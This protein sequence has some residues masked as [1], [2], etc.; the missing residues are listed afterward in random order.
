MKSFIKLFTLGDKV[1]IVS[2]L[3]VALLFYGI[4]A[5][6]AFSEFAEVVEVR[7]DGELYAT[8]SLSEIRTSKKVKIQTDF[9]TN[10]LE[11]TPDGVRITD[12]SCPDKNDVKF[13]KIT[14]VN[15]MLIC[16]PNRLTVRLT[17]D[18]KSKVDKVTY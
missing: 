3:A 9:G 14:K 8:Y 17:G 10:V 12:A 15:Q 18:G 16:L 6:T 2:V 7:V 4:F 13:G 5:V 11:L 1:V